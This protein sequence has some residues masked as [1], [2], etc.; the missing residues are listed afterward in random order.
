MLLLYLFGDLYVIVSLYLIQQSV[1]TAR[2][3]HPFFDATAIPRHGVDENCSNTNK[4]NISFEEIISLPILRSQFGSYSNILALTYCFQ[5]LSLMG[6]FVQ[7]K[8]VS[9]GISGDSARQTF[10]LCRTSV[11]QLNCLSFGVQPLKDDTVKSA[12]LLGLRKLRGVQQSLY[13]MW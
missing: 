4:T 12:L 7:E 3:Q 2:V 11:D 9:W 10:G 5:C 13:T 1:L 6:V 8:V